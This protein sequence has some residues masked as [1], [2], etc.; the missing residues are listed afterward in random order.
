MRGFRVTAIA[1][2]VALVVLVAGM[3][4]RRTEHRLDLA[5]GR[6][7][8]ADFVF[9]FEISSQAVETPFTKFAP[10]PAPPSSATWKVY[11]S[12]WAAKWLWGFDNRGSHIAGSAAADL[13]TF[14]LLCEQ[15]GISEEEGKGLSM[16]LLNL[17]RTGD[18]HAIS[19]RVKS[20]QE[21]LEMDVRRIPVPSC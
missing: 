16:Q 8:R 2:A 4:S 17:L 10:P 21:Y 12:K 5:S 18:A 7:R 3:L 14:A 15:H 6:V 11:S 19:E 20:Y 1:T 9:G 13:K